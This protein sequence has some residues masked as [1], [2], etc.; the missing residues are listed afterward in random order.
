MWERVTGSHSTSD[1]PGKSHGVVSR[2][3]THVQNQAIFLDQAS[4]MLQELELV[5]RARAAVT[6]EAMVAVVG[7]HSVHSRSPYLTSTLGRF[8]TGVKLRHV[9][10]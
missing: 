5:E 3:G 7:P 2:F 6:C 9:K 1:T 4:E 8:T 10:A